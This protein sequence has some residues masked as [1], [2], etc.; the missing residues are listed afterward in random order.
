M[1][2]S[3]LLRT[4][5]IA[6]LLFVPAA[7]AD[8]ATVSG[9]G[10]M[11]LNVLDPVD[12]SVMEAV[13]VY[14]SD[15]NTPV[16]RI[17]PF[18]IAA[19]KAAPVAN[20][21]YPVIMLSHGS[22]GSMWGQH[23][24]ATSLARSGNIVV[25]V[26]HPGG[27][28]QDA[29]RLGSTASLYGRPLQ[30]SATLTAAL[31]DPVLSAHIDPQRIGFVGFSAGGTTGL[32]LADARPDL[33]RLLAYCSTRPSTHGVCEARGQIAVDPRIPK[34]TPDSRIRSLVLLAPLSVI[35]APDTLKG[36]AIPVSIFTGTMDEE[37]D[38]EQNATALA[39]AIGPAAEF[40]S[41]PNA[42][43]YAFLAPCSSASA[44]AIPALC[45]D[46][47]GLDRVD[48]HQS[49]NA[50]IAAFFSRTLASLPE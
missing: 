26:T 20:G 34:P 13:V 18:D 9:A 6:T 2:V 44:R 29:R 22:L 43:H 8:A 23:D 3:M 17:G 15:V 12:Q 41:I 1:G 45:V 5:L 11:R 7:R 28:Y 42:G 39:Q 40:H 31:G 46:P 4:L 21:R 38:M 10:L 14:P 27:N 32:I 47:P 25:S 49:L 48:L 35:F 33:E 24:L 30:V 36:V 16:T 19:S 50:D 37:L